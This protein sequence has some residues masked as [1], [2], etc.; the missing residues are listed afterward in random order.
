MTDEQAKALA[1][2]AAYGRA[3]ASAIPADEEADRIAARLA[4]KRP[5]KSG[6]LRLRRGRQ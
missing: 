6:P 3:L 1:A 5:T 2:W 4:A